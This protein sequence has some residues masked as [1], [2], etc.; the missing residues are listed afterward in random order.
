MRRR[1]SVCMTRMLERSGPVMMKP[2]PV[3]LTAPLSRPAFWVPLSRAGR[4]TSLTYSGDVRLWSI[5]P[6]ET[7]PAT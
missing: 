2:P 4:T 3:I 1:T 6:S 5:N 7:S